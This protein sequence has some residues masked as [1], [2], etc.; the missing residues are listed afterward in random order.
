MSDLPAIASPASTKQEDDIR[1][2]A[3][4][5]WEEEGRPEG[6]AFAHWDRA[7]LVLMSLVDDQSID[8]PDWLQ[9]NAEAPSVTVQ[10]NP[11]PDPKSDLNASLE[12]L[13]RR[14]AGRATG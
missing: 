12:D 9:Q 7:C 11:Q 2:L 5:F 8:Q 3:Y 4:Q 13:R 14:V 6:R 10:S 1:R